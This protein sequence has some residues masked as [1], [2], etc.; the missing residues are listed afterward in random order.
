LSRTPGAVESPDWHETVVS[1]RLD[2][3]DRGEAEFLTV[4]EVERRLRTRME[5]SYKMRERKYSKEE[6]ARRGQEIFCREIAATLE[7]GSKGKIAAI[8][9]ESGS[10]VLGDDTLSASDKLFALHPNAQIWFVRVGYPAVHRF[11]CSTPV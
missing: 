8:D 6:L 11:G 10:F 4:E 1:E 7:P 2:K 9:V 5:Q 3:I